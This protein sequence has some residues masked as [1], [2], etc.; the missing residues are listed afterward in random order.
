MWGSLGAGDYQF[1]TPKGAALDSAGNVYITDSGNGRV[2]KYDSSGVYLAQWGSVGAANGQ[3]SGP[4]G[5]AADSAGNVYVVDRD[6]S[7][8]QKFAPY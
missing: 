5:I 3:F 7:R 4:E 8:V 6:N 2:L 1:N